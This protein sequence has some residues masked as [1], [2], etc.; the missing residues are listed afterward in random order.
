MNDRRQFLKN[1][2]LA[3]AGLALA[4]LSSATAG[5]MDGLPQGLIYTQANP[6]MW[7]KK[8]GGHLPRV[9]V[10]GDKVGVFTKHGMSE[11]HFIVRHTI[12]AHNGKVLGSKTFSPEDEEARSSHTIPAEYR[13][14]KLYATSFCNKHD[15]WVAEFTA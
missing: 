15:M 7:G 12:V 9:S 2:L 13:G 14:Q 8:V 4:P 1:S 6:G 10:D 3:S 11:K 5:S